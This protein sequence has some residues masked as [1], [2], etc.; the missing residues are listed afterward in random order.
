LR[1][2]CAGSTRISTLRCPVW[3]DDTRQLNPAEAKAMKP[4]LPRTAQ[5]VPRLPHVQLEIA[6]AVRTLMGLDQD[7]L[8]RHQP[9]EIAALRRDFEALARD[10][11]KAFE[12]AARLAKAEVYAALKKY[13]ADQPRVPKGNLH[14]G[15]WTKGGGSGVSSDSSRDKSDDLKLR[16]NSATAA[17]ETPQPRLQY[18]ASDTATASDADGAAAR[19]SAADSLNDSHAAAGVER[20][21]D[22]TANVLPEKPTFDTSDAAILGEGNSA[23]HRTAIEKTLTYQLNDD[24][25]YA[26]GVIVIN[27]DGGLGAAVDRVLRTLDG[28]NPVSVDFHATI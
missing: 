19:A 27:D 24:A 26:P 10:I 14:G 20:T 23:E 25:L 8:L 11:P 7:E 17:D 22:Q 6:K 2:S 13:S 4:P 5:A 18:A 16:G 3:I 15:E 9:T 21:S 28:G 1:A 12:E